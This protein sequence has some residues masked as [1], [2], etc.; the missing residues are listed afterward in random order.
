[1]TVKIGN[2]LVMATALGGLTLGCGDDSAPIASGSESSGSE[3]GSTGPG[4]GTTMQADDSG[5]TN[6]GSGSAEG[7]ESSSSGEPPP[8]EVTVEGEVVDFV[9]MGTPIAD[10]EI[11]L[12]DDPSITATSDAMGLFSL[13]PLVAETTALFVVNPNPDYW[14][15]I[16]PIDVGADPL[17][18]DEQLAQIPSAFVDSQI[19]LLDPQLMMAGTVPDLDQAIMIVRLINNTAVGEGPTTVEMSPAPAPGTFYA[20]DAMGA[21][22]LD[23]N[24]IEFNL[25]PVVVFFNVPDTAPGEIS[26]TATHPTR[27]CSVLYPQLPT[28]GQHITLV[29]IQCLT[30]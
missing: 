30:P 27:E 23:Q 29:D 15:A 28:L 4:P 25:L 20:P 24:T 11:T 16:I 22:V 19:M 8:V 6:A 13:G 12:F 10:A 21:P 26:F 18:E 3:T 2:I 1:M 17:Q 14:G 5:T 7:S 9:A